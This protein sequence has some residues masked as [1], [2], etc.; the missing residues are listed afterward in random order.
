MSI[1]RRLRYRA[2]RSKL[3]APKVWL[4]HRGLTPRDV[5]IAS[6]PR[7][8]STWLRFILSEILVRQ[9]GEFDNI[10]DVIPEVHRR[11]GA[12][13]ILPQ[14]GHLIKTHEAYRKEYK[15]AIYLVRD[16]RDVVLSLYARET[17][18]HM[19][20]GLYTSLDDYLPAFLRGKANHW[21]TW[22]GHASSWL[23][24]PIAQAGKLLLVRFEDLRTNPVDVLQLLTDF[25]GV[26]VP[27]AAIQNAVTNNSVEKMR[28]KESRAR[29]APTNAQVSWIGKEG[30]FV[31]QG[32]V[33]G[34][35]DKLTVT[36]LELIDYYAGKELAQLG[37][38]VGSEVTAMVT[39]G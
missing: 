6:Y 19:L 30:R 3:R 23:N 35:R 39:A 20:T 17:E 25:L 7:S 31:R 16:I 8:G 11:R 18:L 2:G 4:Q 1:Y 34:W 14:G 32:S 5:F 37:Y 24:S 27:S 38:P 9:S 21:G 10:N 13:A 12:S 28:A 22:Q 15:R 26:Q 29:T 36:Q 33:R